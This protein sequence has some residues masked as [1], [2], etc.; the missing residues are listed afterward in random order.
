M[1]TGGASYLAAVVL[2]I[3]F[4]VGAVSKFRDIRPVGRTLRAGGIPAS[5]VVAASIP[6]FEIAT[7][8]LLLVRPTVGAVVALASLTL[9]TAFLLSLLIR[10]IDVSCGCFGG[11]DESVSYIDVVRNAMLAT[12]AIL[13]TSCHAPTAFGLNDLVLVSTTSALGLVVLSALSTRRKLGQLFDNRLPG[14]R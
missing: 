6:L 8:A 9:F 12:L 4:L 3:V 10:N 11:N 2:A 1:M 14:E 13:A 5:R 7:A